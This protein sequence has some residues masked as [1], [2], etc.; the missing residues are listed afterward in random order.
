MNDFDYFLCDDLIK[1]WADHIGVSENRIAFFH[2]KFNTSYASA[3]AFQDI[4][5]QAQKNLGNLTPQDFQLESKRNIWNANYNSKEGVNTA[6]SRVRK[7]ASVTDIIEQIKQTTKNP[8]LSKE[9]YLVLN[10]IS[11]S[12]LESF[13]DDLVNGVA[14]N[15]RN[16]VIQILWFISSLINSCQ[17]LNTEVTIYC[18]P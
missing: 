8:Y 4:V 17:E 5:G 10:F 12:D 11:K 6:I 9:V 1:E 18:R 3:S 7:G 14:F 15:E 2:S 13:L 16:E